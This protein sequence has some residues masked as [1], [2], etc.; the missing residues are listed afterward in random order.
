MVTDER[1]IG[2]KNTWTIGLFFVLGLLYALVANAAGTRSTGAGAASD[3]VCTS[4]SPCIQYSNSGTGAGVQGASASGNGLIGTTMFKSTPTTSAA[5]VFGEDLSTSGLF[6]SGVLGTSTRGVGV[7]GNSRTSYG[8]FGFSRAGSGVRGV[9]SNLSSTV[10]QAG[11]VGFDS[12]STSP[13]RN[14][15]VLGTSDIGTGVQG[16]TVSGIGVKA[17]TANGIALDALASG[18]GDGIDITVHGGRAI[19]AQGVGTSSDVATFATNGTTPGVAYLG[20]ANGLGVEARGFAPSSSNVPALNASCS[21]GGPAMT[22]TNSTSPTTK[23]IMSLDC[24]GNMVLAG[25]LTTFGTPLA[26]HRRAGT[27]LGTYLAQQTMATIEDAGEGQLVV[28]QAYVRLAPDFAATIDPRSN[29]LVF[30]TP[31]GESRGLYVTQKTGAGFAVR[32]NGGGH[33]SISFD[34]RIIA[35]PYDEPVRRLPAIG[36]LRQDPSMI[37]IQRRS[38]R[39]QG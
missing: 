23:D 8:V 2:M 6:D 26:V 17:N 3:P 18:T 9:T 30:I 31:Q 7:I 10:A 25:S 5:G 16:A 39:A 12:S 36:Q 14:Q 15:G 37:E 20:F 29:Y 11:V 28:G 27:S 4:S 33:S 38:P 1:W 21:G 19:F 24:S 35:K 34:Y 32:E 22:A 13:D